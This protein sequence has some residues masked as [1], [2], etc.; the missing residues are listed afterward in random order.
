MITT[1]SNTVTVWNTSTLQSVTN[2]GSTTSNAIK[3]TNTGSSIST[4]TGALVVCG[5]VGIGGALNVGKEANF[6]GTATFYD[7]V[8]TEGAIS[9]P[10]FN[11]TTSSGSITFGDGSI[12]NTRAGVLWTNCSIIAAAGAAGICTGCFVLPVQCGGQI[13]VG[14]M[15]Y[16]NSVGALYIMIN[17]GCGNI[18]FNPIF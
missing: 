9:A 11:I 2:K 16:D 13:A 6:Y 8:T 17:Q 1:G 7:G 3:I 12:Q 14:D 18:Q 15:Y 10:S 4:S 5:G